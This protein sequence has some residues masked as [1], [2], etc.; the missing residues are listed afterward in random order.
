MPRGAG[1]LFHARLATS[2]HCA[3]SEEPP[4]CHCASSPPA[5]QLCLQHRVAQDPISQTSALCLLTRHVLPVPALQLSLQ[6]RVAQDRLYEAFY[7]MDDPQAQVTSY[8][9]WVG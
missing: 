3:F 8:G 4:T 9:E 2:A 7:S 1:M 5:W 6:Y